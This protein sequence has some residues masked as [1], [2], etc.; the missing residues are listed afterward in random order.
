MSWSDK[1]GQSNWV[2]PTGASTSPP[3]AANDVFITNRTGAPVSS[4]IMTFDAASDPKINSLT[5]D[6]SPGS[7]LGEFVELYQPNGTLTTGSETIGTTGPAEHFLNGGVNNVTALTVNGSGIYNLG[8]GSLNASTVNVNGGYFFFNGGTANF[9]TFNSPAGRCIGNTYLGRIP[10]QP[11]FLRKR[12]RTFSAAGS[13]TPQQGSSFADATG[14]A[15][16]DQT[17][18]TN[19]AGQFTLGLSGG[20]GVYNL[21]GT[22]AL[23]TSISNTPGEIIVR[24]AWDGVFIQSGGQ[25]SAST[26]NMGSR[27]LL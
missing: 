23:I 24:G 17:G 2:G 13:L 19:N 11:Q 7:G 9:A 12:L 8:A 16:F 15:A 21:S 10:D 22:G 25:N 4:T 1:V 14:G 26:V 6:S 18:G 20:V 27:R 3:T 5:I